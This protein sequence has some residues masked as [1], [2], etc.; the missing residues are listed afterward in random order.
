M[1]AFRLTFVQARIVLLELIRTPGFLV[2]T[3]GFPALFFALFGAPGS[4]R[5]AY[6]D[7]ETLSFMVFAVVGICFYQF[8]VGIAADRGRPWERYLRTLPT[9]PAE[10]FTAR[11][12]VAIVL[13]VL[14]AVLVAIVSRVMTP[15]D[16]TAAQ[17]IAAFGFALAGGVPFVL[18][19]I[20]LGYLVNAR[21]AV[22]IATAGNLLLAYAGGLWIPPHYLPAPVQSISPYLPTREFAELLWSVVSRNSPASAAIGLLAYAV[23]FGDVAAFAYR[24]DERVRYA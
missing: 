20:A 14:A 4:H 16:L 5:P 19:G 1:N 6:A 11:V 10:R 15:I 23:A 2:P 3:V 7:Y 21:A 22:P 9:T 18:M 8:G 12:L 13:G 24:R 17:W